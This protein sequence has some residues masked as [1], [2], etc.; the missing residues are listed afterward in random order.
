MKFGTYNGRGSA[1]G[2]N[3]PQNP[4][5]QDPQKDRESPFDDGSGDDTQDQGDDVFSDY[6]Q[7]IYFFTVIA[8]C[9][10]EIFNERR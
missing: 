8:S 6:W 2:F 5:T 10:R 4:F 1:G 7:I 9:Y 3:N